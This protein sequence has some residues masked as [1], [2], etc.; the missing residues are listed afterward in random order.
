[1]TKNQIFASSFDSSSTSSYSDK[2]TK[3]F[4]NR[5]CTALD[6]AEISILINQE[7][8]NIDDRMS[9]MLPFIHC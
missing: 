5:L 7:F 8:P 1:M 9:D 3:S 4:D 6:H 2:K